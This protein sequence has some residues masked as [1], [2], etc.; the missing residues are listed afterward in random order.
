[1]KEDCWRIQLQ[2]VK[3]IKEV[4][5]RMMTSGALGIRVVG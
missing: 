4:V 2:G 3:G 5:P 1:M